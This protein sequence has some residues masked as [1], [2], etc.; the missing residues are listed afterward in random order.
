MKFRKIIDEEIDAMQFV[1][2]IDGI[3]NIQEFIGKEYHGITKFKYTEC[4]AIVEVSTYAHGIRGYI[5]L[6]DGEWIVKHS[7][8]EFSKYSNEMF[9]KLHERVVN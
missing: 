2:S 5:L 8:R 1:Y 3:K 6:L 4:P 9:N 7:D